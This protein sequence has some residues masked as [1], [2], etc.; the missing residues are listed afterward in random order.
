MEDFFHLREALEGKACELAAG[1]LNAT[2]VAALLK[3]NE[4]LSDNHNSIADHLRINEE[5]HRLIAEC[6][7][8]RILLN[9]FIDLNAHM[10]IVFGYFGS[11]PW[12]VIICPLWPSNT[13][14]SLRRFPRT[15]PKMRGN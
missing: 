9:S 14:K 2:K 11:G 10:Q 7:N 13:M 5:F 3:L 6:A 12:Q 8:N 1:K 15:A 4:L